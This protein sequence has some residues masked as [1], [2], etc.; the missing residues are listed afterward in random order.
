M[1]R[2]VLSMLLAA[3]LI[4][5]LMGTAPPAQ[6][7]LRR[8]LEEAYGFSLLVDGITEKS[9]HTFYDR[10]GYSGLPN[11][12][13]AY[14][15]NIMQTVKKLF[16]AIP[17]EIVQYMARAADLTILVSIDAGE[18][19]DGLYYVDTNT[20]CLMYEGNALVHEYG[21]MLHYALLSVIGE[22]SFE[23]QWTALNQGIGYNN[24][25]G[26][27]GVYDHDT[28]MG[29]DGA[30]F[31]GNYA[32]VDMFEDVAETFWMMTERPADLQQF[33]ANGA[34]LGQK[35]ALL[36]TLLKVTLLE[37]D[38]A[39]VT[40]AFATGHFGFDYA[41]CAEDGAWYCEECEEWHC[42]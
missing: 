34:P 33:I 7:E 21:H 22:A 37:A 27:Q 38:S 41:D 19:A 14:V 17:P 26:G 18:E 20:I 25:R 30:V 36:D 3:L 32:T 10:Y 29:A 9:F 11:S 4:V 2:R 13:D 40:Q 6:E 16:A 5:S 35:A 39:L 42:Y 12:L 8:E 1:K 15:L 31:Y 23:R 28:G 24:G